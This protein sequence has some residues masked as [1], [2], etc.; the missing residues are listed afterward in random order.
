MP[1]VVVIGAGVVGAAA[2][3]FLTEA[4]ARV[5]VLEAND[6]AAGVTAASFAV[7]V[8]RIKTPRML[9]DLALAAG[10]EHAALEKAWGSRRW[11]HRV[12]TLE[13]AYS[14]RDQDRLQR[15]VERLADW[16]YPAQWI[17][18]AEA[19][20]V[21]PEL[22]LSSSVP[23]EIALFPRGARYEPAVLCHEFLERAQFRGASLHVHDP[24]T[25]FK[26]GG[27]RITSVL[28]ASGRRVDADVVVNCAGP[29]AARLAALAGTELPLQRIPGFIASIVSERVRLRAIV[30]AGDLNLRPDGNGRILL[31]SWLQDAGLDPQQPEEMPTRGERLLHQA[32]DVIPGIASAEMQGTRFG[33]RPVPPDGL[34][35]V[36]F[37]S[38]VAN[39]YVVVSHS[40]VHLAPLLGRL[41]A[42]ELAGGSEGR[43]DAFRPGRFKDG[44]EIEFLD[45]SARSM[46]TIRDSATS[47]VAKSRTMG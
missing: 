45:E 27:G 38:D 7:D 42:R 13:W 41:A 5:E 39:L 18:P 12:P 2:A 14:A 9:Y 43:L 33:V 40:G 8:T 20:E 16:G 17:S 22:A 1:D 46:L 34:P 31:H 10:D 29:D 32:R 4:G 24:V 25:E 47:E 15:R 44:E 6:V 21:E 11:V 36:G 30:H 19:Q 35:I 23:D 28:S 37:T 26:M 3:Y